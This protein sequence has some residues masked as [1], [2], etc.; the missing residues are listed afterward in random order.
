MLILCVITLVWAFSFSLIGVYLAPDVDAYI[1]VFIRMVLAAALLLP[2]LRLGA[3]SARKQWQLMG[4]GAIQIGMMYLLLY[5]AFLHISVAEVLLFTIFT[6]L[7]ITLLDEQLLNRKAL[8]LIW[9]IAALLSVIGA[10]LIR[11][12][13]VSSGFWTGFLLI[14]G[15]NLC[16]AFGQVAYKRLALGPARAQLQQYALFFIGACIVSGVGMVLFADFNRMPSTST[17]W[18]I[19][20]W[21]GLG[22]SGVGYMLWSIA[23][24]M[25]N[26]AQLATMN[27]ALIPAGLVVNFLLWG[28]DVNWPNLFFGGVIILLAVWLASRFQRTP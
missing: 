20:I 21:L 13:G 15:A 18:A 14:Q 5:H 2:F 7:Y 12:Q 25:V 4:I 19:L 10:G 17:H 3:M 1:A 8:P 23:S 24:K 11:Y 27:N 28:Q 9:W 26:I 22:A 6:P 16:F